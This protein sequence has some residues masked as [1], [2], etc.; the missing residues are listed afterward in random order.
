ML[1]LMRKVFLAGLGAMFLTKEKAEEMAEELVR[2]GELRRDEARNFVDQLLAKG[3]EQHAQLQETVKR[4]VS[5]WRT[6]WGLVTRAEMASLEKRVAELEAMMA[7]NDRAGG[8][9]DTH[10]NAE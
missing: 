2:R 3:K 8:G 1:D 10:N 6:E 5:R 7:R 9:Q 4:E